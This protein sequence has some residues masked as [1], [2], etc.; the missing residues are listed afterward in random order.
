MNFLRKRIVLLSVV[1]SLLFILVG[2]KEDELSTLTVKSN[3]KAEVTISRSGESKT[4]VGENLQFTELPTGEYELRATAE[5]YKDYTESIVLKSSNEIKEIKLDK[6]PVVKEEATEEKDQ[7]KDSQEKVEVIKADLELSLFDVNNNPLKAKVIL[8]KEDKV[9]ARKEGQKLSFEDL[10]TGDY[11]VEVIREGYQKLVKDISLKE[12]GVEV[13]LYILGGQIK[14]LF[15]DKQN[16]IGKVKAAIKN[17]KADEELILALSYLDFSSETPEFNLNNELDRLAKIEYDARARGIDLV[18]EYGDELIANK[19]YTLGD[20]KEF[21]VSKDLK[22]AN[23]NA[24]LEAV[25]Q[26]IYVFV[27]NNKTVATE[28]VEQL[29]AEFDN[30]IYPKLTKDIAQSKVVVLLTDFKDVPVTGYFNPADLYHDQ[31]NEERMF[32]LNSDRSI[33]TLLTAA[34]HQYQH[35]LFFTDK[36][37]VGRIFNDAWIDQ[38][39]AQLAPR[40]CGYIDYEKEGWSTEKGNGWVYDKDYG[41]LNNTQ[42]VDLLTHDG[43]L[44]FSGA[45]SL[46]ASY[47]LEQYGT[48][49]LDRIMNSSKDPIAVIEDYTD[50]EFSKIYMNWMTTNITDTINEIDNKLY[51]YNS[52]ELQRMPKFAK[53]K[54]NPKGIYYIKLDS[55]SS[56]NL[57][58]SRID[59]SGKLG[60]VL[61]KKK[62]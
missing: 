21:V 27:D 13:P 6:I 59:G 15:V 2:C 38:G 37:K 25:G 50:Q 34:A 20:E 42:K 33:N 43:S 22:K 3:V 51:K 31:G 19:V 35:L 53:Q 57:D 48:E 46:F 29:V 62:K 47:V 60:I 1:L 9:I 49:L 54:I 8:K 41:Y 4:L 61:I 56:L 7:A 40:V 39:L 14:Q 26:H 24:T 52:F 11:K 17:I 58:L 30:V 23:V 5:G 32:Y 18:K 16:D 12:D 44:A 36:A 45:S 55:N 10:N 28:K